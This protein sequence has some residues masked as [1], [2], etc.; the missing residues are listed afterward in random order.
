ML[1]TRPHPTLPPPHTNRHICQSEGL[2]NLNFSQGTIAYILAYTSLYQT[3]LS[4]GT[5]HP[6]CV[7]FISHLRCINLR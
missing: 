5:L 6:N 1:I 3:N 2:H 4:E 7:V